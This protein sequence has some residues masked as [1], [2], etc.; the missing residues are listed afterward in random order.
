M[1]S[2]LTNKGIRSSLK[3]SVFKPYN[4]KED[5]M[6]VKWLAILACDWPFWCKYSMYDKRISVFTGFVGT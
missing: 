5:I 3:A 6:P 1:Q 4:M 2:A